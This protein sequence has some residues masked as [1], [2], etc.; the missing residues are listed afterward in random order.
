MSIQ[1][2]SSTITFLYE[3]NHLGGLFLFAVLADV[4]LKNRL[5]STVLANESRNRIYAT[6]INTIAGNGTDRVPRYRVLMLVIWRVLI[7][8]ASAFDTYVMRHVFVLD[9][10]T[11]HCGVNNRFLLTNT[12]QQRA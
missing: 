12:L 3:D 9:Y 4:K 2:N 5:H 10:L 6:C 11:V 1:V 7:Q 8:L